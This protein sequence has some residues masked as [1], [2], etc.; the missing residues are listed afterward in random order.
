MIDFKRKKDKLVLP[1]DIVETFFEFLSTKNIKQHTPNYPL[2]QYDRTLP[3]TVDKQ[4]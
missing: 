4:T 2:N 3:S 1:V